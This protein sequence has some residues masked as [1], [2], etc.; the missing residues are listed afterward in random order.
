MSIPL[1]ASVGSEP[2]AILSQRIHSTAGPSGLNKV[3]LAPPPPTPDP[4]APDPFLMS[5]PFFRLPQDYLYELA[6]AVRE[7][8]PQAEEGDKYLFELEAAVRALD[9][10]AAGPADGGK[11]EETL[12]R[13][14]GQV[15]VVA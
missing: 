12:E 13:E 1:I 2:L 8:D 10:D 14:A 6:T 15:E 11:K 4:R 3:S 5:A 9:D 7:L